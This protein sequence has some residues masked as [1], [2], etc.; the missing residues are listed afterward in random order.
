MLL[1]ANPAHQR[2]IIYAKLSKYRVRGRR[3]TL[4][5]AFPQSATESS[6]RK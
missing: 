6:L 2:L 5:E 3:S 1:N 4:V